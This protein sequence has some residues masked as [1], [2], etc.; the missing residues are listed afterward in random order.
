MEVLKIAKN[1][2]I[3]SEHL[4]KPHTIKQEAHSAGFFFFSVLFPIM[5]VSQA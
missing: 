5:T 1:L 2:I 4:Q 3:E